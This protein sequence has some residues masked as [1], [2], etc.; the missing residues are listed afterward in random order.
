M[1]YEEE[2]FSE[3]KSR[4]QLKREVEALQKLGEKLIK[5][6]AA[7][8]AKM[9]LDE[10]LLSAI[11]HAQQINSRGAIRRQRQY[12]GKLMREADAEAIQQAYDN[13]INAGAQQNAQF[14]LLERL[15]DKLLQ[16]DDSAISEVLEHFPNAD[17]GQI[18]Q[19]TR[20]AKAEQSKGAP[21]KS[22]RKLFKYL[23]E[24]AE[25]DQES[26]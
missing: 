12:I 16:E 14:H 13:I 20:N 7:D 17:R 24:V 22:A 15:R 1:T 5:L 8:L 19:L 3:E 2:E 11:E 23:R 26:D 9:N 21:P 18:R 10:Q 25:F 4:S 6:K